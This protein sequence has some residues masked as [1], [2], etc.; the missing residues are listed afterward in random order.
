[1]ERKSTI[2]NEF[3]HKSI[4]EVDYV[5]I[6]SHE[7]VTMLRIICFTSFVSLCLVCDG[8]AC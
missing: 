1:M 6:S 8:N 5:P 7:S 3:D 2:S 4:V